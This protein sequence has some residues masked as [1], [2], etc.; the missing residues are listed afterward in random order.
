MHDLFAAMQGQGAASAA[1][2]TDSDGDAGTTAAIGAASAGVSGQH[3]HH[4]GGAG[5]IEA[6]LQNL[7][8]QLSS[9]GAASGTGT[10]SSSPAISTLQQ[11]FQN[12]LA[13]S[14]SSGNQTSLASFLQSMSQNL[15]DSNPGLNVSTSA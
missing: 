8:A 6:K 3:H 12:L 11:D 4:G 9:P 2:A 14:G 7:I 1:A 13:S 5:G 15:Q 10:A